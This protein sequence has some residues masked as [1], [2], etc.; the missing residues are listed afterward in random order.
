MSIRLFGKFSKH[1]RTG[2]SLCLGSDRKFS[3]KG[4]RSPLL[5]CGVWVHILVPDTDQQMV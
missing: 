5:F 1:H 4:E 2:F 3:G